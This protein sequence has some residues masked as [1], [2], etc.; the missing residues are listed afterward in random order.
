MCPLRILHPLRVCRHH[1]TQFLGDGGRGL[2][3]GEG[4]DDRVAAAVVARK[5]VPNANSHD[6]TSSPYPTA[7][8]Q[9]GTVEAEDSSGRRSRQT[10]ITS[11]A[12]PTGIA[13]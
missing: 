3:A 1:C 10:A 2:V 11:A 6:L 7:R 5:G 12:L 9:R 8:A 4:S 13:R